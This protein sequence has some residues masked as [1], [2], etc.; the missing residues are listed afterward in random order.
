MCG[1]T[2]SAPMANSPSALL[3]S[4]LSAFT[5]LHTPFQCSVCAQS[6][7]PKAPRGP[8]LSFGPGDSWMMAV[9]TERW[10][11]LVIATLKLLIRISS[12]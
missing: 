1:L 3:Q 9:V 8:V 11:T 12:W 4:A 5:Y 10:D 6:H 7:L 2:R